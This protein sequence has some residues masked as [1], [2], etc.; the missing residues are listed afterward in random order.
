MQLGMS[1][2][3]NTRLLDET[4]D[5]YTTWHSDG[6]KASSP[7]KASKVNGTHSCM[8]SLLA[9]LLLRSQQEVGLFAIQHRPD[10]VSPEAP[11]WMRGAV[12]ATMKQLGAFLPLHMQVVVTSTLHG[13]SVSV[14]AVAL[15]TLM[16]DKLLPML[17]HTMYILVS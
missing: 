6:I 9:S 11:V 17:Q 3:L 2:L 16:P 13:S 8:Q 14:A 12:H 15:H 4:W 10:V 7:M 1:K 5:A